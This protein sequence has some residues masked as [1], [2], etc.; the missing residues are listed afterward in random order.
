MYRVLWHWRSIEIYSYPAMLYLGLVFGVAAGNYAAHLA[1]LNAARVFVGTLLLLIP[2]L[3]GARLLSVASHWEIYRRDPGRIWRRSEGGGAMYGG[4]PFALL[5]SVPLLGILQVP[6]GAF[7]DVA[8]FTILVAMIFTRLGCLLNGCCAGRATRGWFA[9]YLPDHQGIWQRRIPTQLLEMAWTAAL[10]VGAVA[11]WQ[12]MPFR[13][14]L[15]LYALAGYGTGRFLLEWTRESRER[16][17]KILLHQAI[18]AVLVLVSLIT[19]FI[20]WSG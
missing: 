13:G 7:W 17:G 16:V 4:L 9:L 15:F 18:S 5:I 20:A 14:A 1:N 8:T 3:V 11:L 19:L 6:F 2:S 10:L 12:Q